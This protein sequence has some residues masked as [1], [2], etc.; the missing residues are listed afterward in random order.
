MDAGDLLALDLA[1]RAVNAGINDAVLSP[2]LSS[3]SSSS[4]SSLSLA[5]GDVFSSDNSRLSSSATKSVVPPLALW[6]M[7]PADVASGCTSGSTSGSS[8][9]KMPSLTHR[10]SK[11]TPRK[12]HAAALMSSSTPRSSSSSS[13]T[14]PRSYSLSSSSDGDASDDVE[15]V[16]PILASQPAQR[17]AAPPPHVPKLALGPKAGGAQTGPKIPSSPPKVSPIRHSPP[18]GPAVPHLAGVPPAGRGVPGLKLAMLPNARHDADAAPAPPLSA[19]SSQ[20]SV[21]RRVP[22]IDLGPIIHE[23]DEINSGRARMDPDDYHLPSPPGNPRRIVP[24]A[25]DAPDPDSAFREYRGI[26]SSILDWL[27]LTGEG[28]AAD[29][30]LLKRSGVTHVLN[31]ASRLCPTYFPDH[32]TYWSLDLLDDGRED[33]ICLLYNVIDWL[34]NVRSTKGKVVVHCQAG[35]SRS[36][37]FVIA[38]VMW[39][40]KWNMRKALEFVAERRKVVSPNGGFLVQLTLWERLLAAYAQPPPLPKLYR[41]IPHYGSRQELVMVGKEVRA[42]KSSL[43]PRGCF[44]LYS[45]SQDVYIWRGSESRSGLPE[46]AAKLA[47]QLRRFRGARSVAEVAEGDEGDAFWSALADVAGPVEYNE[48]YNAQYNLAREDER[49]VVAYR[50]PAWEIVPPSTP[51]LE[52]E[53]S[54][55]LWVVH[56]PGRHLHVWTPAKFIASEGGRKLSGDDLL[57]AAARRF[58]SDNQLPLDTP[59]DKFLTISDCLEAMGAFRS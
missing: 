27:L 52:A 5:R 20:E 40:M 38:Y 23:R 2:S 45:L 22:S 3:S 12:G 41:I 16:E 26:I 19:A 57:A 9:P 59:I 50:F 29:L 44:V 18:T 49:A 21:R 47:S 35:V 55:Q 31:C 4:S 30:Q 33:L 54:Q 6:R 17:A 10:I 28:A 25:D 1:A 58:L 32:F 39:A 11:Q 13:D 8:G 43:D 37:T 34:E 48:S 42:T 46:G 24:P 53:A 7:S 15:D 56:G 51:H 14:S 36:A